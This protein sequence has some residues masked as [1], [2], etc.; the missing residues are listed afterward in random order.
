LTQNVAQAADPLIVQVLVDARP[1]M[2]EWFLKLADLS[3]QPNG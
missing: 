3:R 1:P 2:E